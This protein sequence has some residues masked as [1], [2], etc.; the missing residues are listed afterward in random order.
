MMM[1]AQ[2]LP[3]WEQRGSALDITGRGDPLPDSVAKIIPSA[4]LDTFIELVECCMEIGII[5]MYG[6]STEQPLTFLGKC[7]DFLRRGSIRHYTDLS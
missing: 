2:N 4:S 3:E 7:I 1:S 5:D 6:A